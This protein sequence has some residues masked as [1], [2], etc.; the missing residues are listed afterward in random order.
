MKYIV[1]DSNGAFFVNKNLKDVSDDMYDAVL[2]TEEEA[3]KIKSS[4]DINDDNPQYYLIPLDVENEAFIESIID[5]LEK[6]LDIPDEEYDNLIHYIQTNC[7]Q[8]IEDK[9]NYH[10]IYGQLIGDIAEDIEL[11]EF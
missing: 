8:F 4:I 3:K 10:K 11:D 5:G 1:S 6:W 7:K 2:F 9:I